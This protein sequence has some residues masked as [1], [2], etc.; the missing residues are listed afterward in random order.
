MWVL[1]LRVLWD[2]S[3]IGPETDKHNLDENF[4]KK[5]ST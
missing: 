4:K 3:R 2:V 1:L 5:K